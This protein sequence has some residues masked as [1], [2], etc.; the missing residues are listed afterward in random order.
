MTR[1]ATRFGEVSVRYESHAARGEIR[2]AADLALERDPVRILARFRHPD[3][4]PLKA[5]RVNGRPWR[6]FDRRKCDVDLTGLRGRVNVAA[7]F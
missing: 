3:G 4:K 1:A 5:V 6:R 7:F 2:L